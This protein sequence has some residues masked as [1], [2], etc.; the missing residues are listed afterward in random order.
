MGANQNS[1]RNLAY[2]PKS[3]QI[4]NTQNPAVRK[5]A[6]LHSPCH[7]VILR[8]KK[9]SEPTEMS[10]LGSTGYDGRTRHHALRET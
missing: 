8:A 9:K 10:A 7:G 6:R 4:H 3:T 5:P 2:I 1:S